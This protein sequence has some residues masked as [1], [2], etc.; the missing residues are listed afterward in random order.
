[1]SDEGKSVKKKWTKLRVFRTIMLLLI[2]IGLIVAACFYIYFVQY[3]TQ[4]FY[5]DTKVNGIDCSDLTEDEAA[6][7]LQNEIDKWEIEIKEREGATEHLTA[8]DI[9]MT[10]ENDGSLRD[11]YVA[12]QP[13][14]WG[15]RIFG[16][17]TYDVPSG[18][19]YDEEKL[20]NHFKN[21]KQVKDFVPV[22]DA[23]IVRNED[24]T[25]RIDPEVVGTEMDQDAAF[26]ALK[27]AVKNQ[28]NELDLEEFYKNPEVHADD[29]DLV[30]EN[31]RLNLI[32][33]LTKAKIMVQF[34]DEQITIDESMLKD[35]IIQDKVEKYKID[36]NKVHEFVQG[37]YDKY[38]AGHE[39]QLFKTVTG[40]VMTLTTFEAPGWNIDVDK[41]CERYLEA[42]HE[43]YQGVLGPV[44][45]RLDENGQETNETYVEISIDEQHMWL[46]VNGEPVVDTP[47]VTGGADVGSVDNYS[48]DYIIQDF[49]S[50]ATPSNGIWTIKKK[51]SPHYMKGPMLS[52]GYYEYTLDVTY[53]LPFND[54][55]GIHDNWQRVD[56]G[57]KIYQTSGS[58]GC[59]NTPFDAVEQIYNTVDVG[60][61][62][63]VY[64]M[65]KGEDVFA[66]SPEPTEEA[67]EGEPS[68]DQENAVEETAALPEEQSA[69]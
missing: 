29:A 22:K 18:F 45:S 60:T 11:L 50:R 1:M 63:I 68:A 13:L 59:V 38:N 7:L 4:H 19:V 12:Q 24:G 6:V 28:V 27:D 37:L 23:E 25:Y 36:E 55:V 42:I 26:E 62:V 14:L 33:A 17:K 54:Q 9:D 53:W 67:A 31:E 57:G 40:R 41:S 48:M 2:T 32:F 10:Y 21:F 47:I 16:E 52:S 43:G 51:E 46:M 49:N 20:N 3:Y 34:G 8:K 61:M 30:E 66:P 44:M 69:E 5:D 56:Y 65:D 64:G 58:H 35:W 39:G 15:I